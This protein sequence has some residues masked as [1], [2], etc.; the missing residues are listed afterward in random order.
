MYTGIE[1]LSKSQVEADSQMSHFWSENFQLNKWGW[2]ELYI[3]QCIKVGG[4]SMNC[5]IQIQMIAY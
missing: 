5:L 3:R 4:I 2:L 1:Q